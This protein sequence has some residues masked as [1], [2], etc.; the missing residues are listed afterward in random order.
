MD[1]AGRV[2]HPRLIYR[3]FAFKRRHR[4]QNKGPLSLG[5][6]TTYMPVDI[7]DQKAVHC[8][9]ETIQKTQ[10]RLSGILHCAG[11]TCDKLI[12]E[13]SHEEFSRVLD[14]KVSGL[15]HLDEACRDLDL[16]PDLLIL[17]SSV[18]GALGNLGQADYAQPMA[19]WTDLPLIEML[20]FP[21]SNAREKPFD[22]LASLAGRRDEG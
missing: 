4:V 20:L 14:R 10:G 17:F 21:A 22:Q 19:L 8:L 6:E 18:A 13:K 16:D 5:A 1:I 12:V 7:T 2:N 9:I 11:V 15:L 3:T